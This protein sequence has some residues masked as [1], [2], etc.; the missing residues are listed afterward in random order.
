MV[1]TCTPTHGTSGNLVRVVGVS[2]FVRDED[3]V[4]FT[5]IDDIQPL[6]PEDTRLVT[7]DSP[8]FVNTRLYLES[9]L[10]RTPLPQ[11]ER[12]LAMTNSFLMDD[13]V[14]QQRPAELALR[15][16]RPRILLAD[17]VGLGKTM[18]IGL[19]LAELIRRGRGE[20]I[21]VVTP[22]QVLEQFQQELWTRFAIPLVRLDSVGLERIQRDIPAGRNPFLYFNRA[23]IS[24][25]TLKN[26]GRY[27]QHLRSMH[28]DAVVFDESHN[29]IN[30]GNLRNRLAHT[31]ADRTD[32]LLLASATPHNGDAK[33]FAELIRMLDPT[34]IAD[35]ENF[36]PADIQH[37]YLRR[38]KINPEVKAQMGSKWPERGPSTPVYCAPSAAEQEILTELADTW[39]SANAVVQPKDRLVPY[40]LAKAFLSSHKALAAT[41]TT[42][43]RTLTDTA[44]DTATDTGT[45]QP[46]PG[47]ENEHAALERLCD[48]AAGLDDADSTKR[49]ALVETLRGIGVGAGSDMRAVVFCESVPTLEWLSQGIP[50][51]L[52][53]S[54]DQAALLH[55]GL[56]DQGQMAVIDEFSRA[57]SPVRV[58]FAGDVASEGVNLHEQCHH[59][60]HYDVPWSLIRMEQRN[61]RIDRYGQKYEPQFAALLLRSRVPGA[62]DDTTVA[63]KVLR[64]EETA[65]HSMG[66]AEAVVGE[67]DWRDEDD[68]LTRD[69]LEG[70]DP[71]ES[72]D[73]AAAAATDDNPM[74][75]FFEDDEQVREPAPEPEYA[76]V[77][78]LFDSTEQFVRAALTAV[79][80]EMR[81]DDDGTILAFEPPPDLAN[82]LRA[83]P[84]AYL[85]EQAVLSRMRVTFDREHAEKRRKAARGGAENQDGQV[86]AKKGASSGKRRGKGAGSWPD[87]SYV[88][89]LHPLTQ[90]LVD[91]AQ[92]R[93][94]RSQAPVLVAEVSEPV[95][96]AQGVYSNAAGQ[97]TVVEWMAVTGPPHAMRVAEMIPTLQAA[98]VGPEMINPGGDGDFEQL[99]KLVEPAVRQAREHLERVRGDYDEQI[100]RLLAEPQQQ[101]RRWE[102]QTLDGLP[103]D[104]HGQKRRN[105][106][107]ATVQSQQDLMRQMRTTGEPLIRILAVL[108]GA[109]S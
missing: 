85:R 95:V 93:L 47:A 16:L 21:L 84:G 20:R 101:L 77:P 99:Q 83:L 2:E 67:V 19:I 7:D 3:A 69:L 51:E 23:I 34:A 66:S 59:I 5:E 58:L 8:A 86:A 100:E 108:K 22:Q 60:V 50:A 42:R 87:T 33:S 45:Q 35:P 68:R 94:H 29:L 9:A 105:E 79:A 97:P 10:R 14:Y 41:A 70:R 62:I 43:L 54:G 89:D 92:V 104:G 26:Q 55:G 88:T 109:D 102:Q 96:L 73:A 28:W 36:A 65:H 38:T 40:G 75:S 12:R 30:R 74:A 106:V 80:P 56:S 90:W 27:G 57:D 78:R 6:R 18:E 107:A 17:V 24:V 52:G 48:L 71:E 39:L 72:M 64:R 46:R 98:G 91:K 4:F 82:R 44:T 76:Q 61:G 49:S 81:V 11:T 63:E 15:G 103:E 37:L 13:Q 53:L 31:L 1:R 25:D 32:A